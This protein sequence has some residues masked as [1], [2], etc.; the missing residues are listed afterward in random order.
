MRVF[1]M[2][3]LDVVIYV[4]MRIALSSSPFIFDAE[5]KI[6]TKTELQLVLQDALP[7]IKLA[8]AFMEA[9]QAKVTSEQVEDKALNSLV[10]YVDKQT[11]MMLV[12][13]LQKILPSA[14][15]ITEEETVKNQASTSTWIIDPLDGTTNYLHGLPH[16]A[17]S[18]GLLYE[19]E[20]V[21]GIIYNPVSRECFTAI[22]NE[23]AYLNGQRIKVS[24]AANFRSS[25]FVTGFPFDDKERVE[26]N[27]EVV[28]YVKQHSRGIRRFGSAALDLAFV[29]AGRF[30]AYFE[31]GI[32]AWDVSAGILLVREAGGIVTDYQGAADCL[33][34]GEVVAANPNI[35]AELLDVV[36]RNYYV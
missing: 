27:L 23:G 25:L 34:S 21:L 5:D 17:T 10:S 15:F 12:E 13:G 4:A 9:E 20:L 30:E 35:H 36:Q 29:A 33:F 6:M 3:N 22:R 1:Y 26:K 8:G 19:N 24:R 32:N 16:F 7:T 2:R 11:E 14:T 18:V 28:K 31:G